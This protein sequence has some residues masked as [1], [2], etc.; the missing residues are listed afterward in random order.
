MP[1]H[2]GI[3]LD[4][5]GCTGAKFAQRA[6]RKAQNE[7]EMNSNSPRTPQGTAASQ[8]EPTPDS[9]PQFPFSLLFVVWLAVV[10]VSVLVTVFLPEA[11]CSTARIKVER[12]QTDIRGLSDQAAV[13]VH[14][15]FFL[16]TELE[17]VQSEAV[18]TKVIGLCDLNSKWGVKMGGGVKLRTTDSIGLLKGRMNLKLVR[19]TSMVEISVYS[20]DRN[21]A[22]N[23]ANAV[24]DA[25]RHHRI[26]Q[27][28]KT[29]AA[30]VK[31]LEEVYQEQRAKLAVVLRCF[32]WNRW[33]VLGHDT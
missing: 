16:Q 2:C 10:L 9:S 23:L 33:V 20:E 22:A 31:A 18:L 32:R 6:K 29:K 24:A 25:Y 8:P 27:W 26:Q 15:P 4:K 12:D 13:P 1:S 14:D 5:I 19:N 11:F 3:P 21:E 7:N 28:L 17:S 30:G